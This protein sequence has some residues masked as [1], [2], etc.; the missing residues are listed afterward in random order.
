MS[1]AD[2]VELTER[3]FSQRGLDGLADRA[4]PLAATSDGNPLFIEELTASLAERSTGTPASS[5]AASG[6]SSLPGS[7]RCPSPSGARSSTLPSW[8]RCSGAERSSGSALTARTSRRSSG[9]LERRDLIR[10]EATSRIKGEQQFA[11]KHGLIR[12]VAYLTLP[13]EER[14]RCHRATAEYLE[15]VTLRAGD[16]DATLAYHWRE[17]G[18]PSPRSNTCSR[19]PTSRV[20]AGRRRGPSR[21]TGRR[22]SWSPR[23][24]PS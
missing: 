6:A 9:S 23:T 20:A 1:D 2:A 11:F 5:R 22:W 10:R 14:R 13:R 3:L 4:G 8:A 24:P 7:I 12:E 15:E 17:A 21:S 16:A 19:R 18:D